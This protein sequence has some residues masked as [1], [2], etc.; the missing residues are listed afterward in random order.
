MQYPRAFTLTNQQAVAQKVAALEKAE[1]GLVMASGMAA[2]STS[3]LS[4]LSPGDELLI[5]SDLYGGTH[6]FIHHQLKEIGVKLNFFSLSEQDRVAEKITS[7]TKVLYIETPTNP[8]LEIAD[9]KALASIAKEHGLISMADNTFASPV[10]QNPY[11][12]GIDLVIHSGSKYLGGHSDILFGVVVGSK[13]HIEQIRPNAMA[14]GGVLDANACSLAE[15]SI[16]TLELRVTK[17]CENALEL[18][19]FL[20]TL[21]QVKR[22]YYPGLKEHKGHALASSQMKHYGAVVSFELQSFIDPTAFQQALSLIIPAVSLGGI[23]SLIT[24]PALTSHHKVSKEEREQ[25]GISD[26]TLRLSAGIE[27]LADLKLYIEEA[28]K[29][30]SN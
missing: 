1:A 11:E 29:S 19:S 5:Q 20:Q 6:S 4:F 24:S 8:L 7:K 9:I 23:E 13:T 14:Y 10:C 3:L 26:Y 16:K 12:L 18:A 30:I 28:L 2:I 21:P 15:R 17:Q 22:V 25:M 27:G